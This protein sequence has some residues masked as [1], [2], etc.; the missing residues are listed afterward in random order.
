M[1]MAV[2][3]GEYLIIVVPISLT[4]EPFGA[5]MA[6]ARLKVAKGITSVATRR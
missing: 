4:A 3:V 5:P 2:R 1:R 6:I